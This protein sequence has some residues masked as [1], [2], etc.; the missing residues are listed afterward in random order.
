MDKANEAVRGRRIK[1]RQMVG[2]VGGKTKDREW[3]KKMEQRASS[4][5]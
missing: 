5:V 4:R 3:R 2:K 1:V